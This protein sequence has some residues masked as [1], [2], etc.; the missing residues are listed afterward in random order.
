MKIFIDIGHPAHVHYFKNFIKIMET[1]GH[2]F[3]ISSRE[4]ECTA[5][6]L[7]SYNLPFFSR[8]KGRNGAIGKILYMLKADYLLYRKAKQFNPDAFLSFMSPYAAQVSKI[9]GKPHFT[10]DD[11]DHATIARKFYLPFT[12]KVFTPFCFA[13]NIGVKQVRF[14]SFMELSYLHPKYYTPDPSI[15]KILGLTQHQPYVL[16]RF[17]SW[18]ANH[19][20]GQSGLTLE[21]KRAIVN[22]F[23]D[24]FKVFISSEGKLTPDLEEYRI[25]IPVDRMHDV[26]A[27]AKMFVGEGAT[28]AS[29]CAML[30]TPAI[31]INSLD[32]GTLKEQEKLGLIFGYRNS[33]GVIDK[34]KELIN[35]ENL[36]TEFQLKKNEMLQ[37]MIDPT[38]MLV[39][40]FK[41]ISKV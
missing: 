26:L 37:Q 22:L 40:F 38:E 23:K 20:I 11:T 35:N 6:L 9:L 15:Y 12:D 24:K 33:L 10:F 19:D 32:A 25:K 5:E 3:F 41:N 29:E 28:M 31:Y 30:G 13:K 16:L 7:N 21:T 8:G 34:I 18:N 36:H 1:K 2:T 14:K 17:V 4:K 39:N 27:H